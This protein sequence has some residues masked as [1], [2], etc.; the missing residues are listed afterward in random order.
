M[1]VEWLKTALQNLD[2]EATYLAAH[3]PAGAADFIQLVTAAVA[4]MAEFPNM[5]R[6]GRVL[7]TREWSIPATPY[8]IPYRVRANRLQ[9]LRIFHTRRAP[10]A[11][12]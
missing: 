6:Q 8:V 5:G 2:D 3:S 11:T 10:P 9:I 4:R 7:G 12:W 1:Q